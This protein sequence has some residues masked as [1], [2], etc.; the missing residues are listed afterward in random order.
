[1][2]LPVIDN[3]AYNLIDAPMLTGT[4]ERRLLLAM[5]ERAILDFVGNDAAEVEE[6]EGWIF[7]ELDT[8]PLKPFTFPWVCQHL[9]LDVVSI[10]QTIKAM[11]R[12]GKNRVAP[13][14]FNKPGANKAASA[15]KDV[16]AKVDASSA[17][18]DRPKLALVKKLSERDVP[19][20]LKMERKLER[21]IA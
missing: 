13:W 20:N 14:Y 1:V 3:E 17:N 5:I 4:P 16:A 11:P 9:D 19:R 8:A 18:Q 6:A 21:V 7:G 10:A 2:F 15:E 12:R